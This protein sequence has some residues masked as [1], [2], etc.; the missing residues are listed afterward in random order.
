MSERVLAM[1]DSIR[2]HRRGPTI[3]AILLSVAASIENISYVR[4]DGRALRIVEKE[5]SQFRSVLEENWQ[6]MAA[7]V[8]LLR[9]C[10][11]KA[12]VPKVVVGDGRR[13]LLCGIKPK[14][15]DL[16]VTSPPYPNNIDYSEV[17]KLELWL[18]RLVE[19]SGQFL[20]LRRST[21]RSHPTC[22]TPELVPA[23]DRARKNGHLR[24]LLDPIIERADAVGEPWRKKVLLGY[25]SDMWVTLEQQY[26][27]LKKG[28][29]AVTVVG[30]SLHGS[31]S[32]YLIPSD[33]VTACIA[34]R[35]GFVVQDVIISRPLKRRLSGNHFLRESV[36]VLRKE[37]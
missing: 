6:M 33:I 13:P 26:E 22:S 5:R 34:E 28:G 10:L 32:P 8:A 3:D 7:D 2:D 18:L 15:I 29:Y 16:I 21:F 1:A 35:L 12:R 30:N 23:F 19:S 4:K 27:C 20:K 37:P 14:S 24:S 36:V 9:Q 11:P 17:Y 31:A 25:F